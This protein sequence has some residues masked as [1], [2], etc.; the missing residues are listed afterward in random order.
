MLWFH[1]LNSH[2][3][4]INCYF[5]IRF[6]TSKNLIK[7]F[8]SHCCGNGRVSIFFP[9]LKL[10][11]PAL[12]PPAPSPPRLP[13]SAS[14]P[15]TYVAGLRVIAAAP[16]TGRL[17]DPL[18]GER[19]TPDRHRDR[20]TAKRPRRETFFGYAPIGNVYVRRRRRRESDVSNDENSRRREAVACAAFTRVAIRPNVRVCVVSANR[21]IQYN[22]RAVKIWKIVEI[23]KSAAKRFCPVDDRRVCGTG[24]KVTRG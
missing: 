3:H 23:E 13:T 11:E 17:P 20:T 22:L 14:S 19:E 7:L 12:R 21:K 5:S 16:S 24:T 18:D 6:Y 10:L 15:P 8:V 9:G 1:K 2:F 4:Y